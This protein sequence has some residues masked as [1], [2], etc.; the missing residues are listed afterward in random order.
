[1]LL[2]EVLASSMHQKYKK[3]YNIKFKQW[4]PT[5][6]GKC[7]L[8]DRSYLYQKFNTILTISFRNLKKISENYPIKTYVNKL[9]NSITFIIK[10]WIYFELLKPETRKIFQSTKSNI[11]IDEN[12]ENVYHLRVTEKCYLILIFSTMNINKIKSFV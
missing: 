10:T 8:L 6:N 2:H 7:E 12:G 9:E 11:L 4:A 5:W 3:S 1:M